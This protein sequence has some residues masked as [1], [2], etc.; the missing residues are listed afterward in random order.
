MT[1]NSVTVPDVPGQLAPMSPPLAASKPTLWHNHLHACFK[2]TCSTNHSPRQKSNRLTH[3]GLR[4]KG[5]TFTV[6]RE[7]SWCSGSLLTAELEVV[8]VVEVG[9]LYTLNSS[10][11][12]P[13]RK[14]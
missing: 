1:N 6:I 7:V 4:K 13:K 3:T 2:I 8:Y 10:E 5:T 11:I 9:H 14:A 12:H